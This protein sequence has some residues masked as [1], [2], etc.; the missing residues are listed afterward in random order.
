MEEQRSKVSSKY[1][2]I[3]LKPLYCSL[4]LSTILCFLKNAV[5]EKAFYI[6]LFGFVLSDQSSS[7]SVSSEPDSPLSQGVLGSLL[8]FCLLVV[9]H[10]SRMLISSRSKGLLCICGNE[11]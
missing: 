8:N 1:R 6:I 4:L 2:F 7:V 9:N 5:S 3:E 11:E 10:C